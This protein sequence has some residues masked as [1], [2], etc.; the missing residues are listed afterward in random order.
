MPT[1]L[2][3]HPSGDLYGSDRVLLET[4][5]GLVADSARVIVTVPSP[6][7]LVQELV[8][9]GAHVDYC[10]S[11]VLRKSALTLAG[12]LKLAGQTLV[13]VVKSTQLLT[14][15][16]PDV[17]YVNTVTIPLWT[18]LPR[19]LGRKVVTHVHEAE[20]QAS[21]AVRKALAMPLLFSS[22]VL[23]NS[24]Y[25]CHVMGSSWKS[26]NK[27]ASVIDNGIGGPEI[28]SPP[29]E[30]LDGAVRLLYI[31]RLS[32]RKG[33]D[34]AVKAVADLHQRGVN[35]SLDIVGNVFP[36]NE[37]YQ[38]ELLDLIAREGLSE[39]VSFHGFQPDVWP[40]LSE[41]DIALVPSVLDEGFG[42]TAVEA[43]MAAR[44]VVVSN[45]SGLRE[46]AGGYES[47]QLV[48]PSDPK[49]I[50]DAVERVAGDWSSWRARAVEDSAVATARHDPVRY[51]KRLSAFLLA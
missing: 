12:A 25:T 13:S 30:D 11:P 27:R 7:P 1:V 20:G 16:R 10:P 6:G 50:A 5:E 39:R 19:L 33:V 21:A 35:T 31:G 3:A 46:A 37:A 51:R 24:N 43:V 36:G 45:T 47:A 41:A 4:V 9:S 34:V 22:D 2:V 15:Y 40:Y 18:V 44:P 32:R 8:R 26:L 38:E 42:N 29:R 49:A 48:D 14:R 17:V 23:A 28:V